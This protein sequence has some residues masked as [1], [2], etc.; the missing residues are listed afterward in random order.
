MDH[1]FY[2]VE[3]SQEILSNTFME[4]TFASFP[5]PLTSSVCN[6]LSKVVRSMQSIMFLKNSEGSYL[7]FLIVQTTLWACSEH[8]PWNHS[9]WKFLPTYLYPSSSLCGQW[10]G[11]HQGGVLAARVSPATEGGLAGLRVESMPGMR[12]KS[13]IRATCWCGSHSLRRRKEAQKAETAGEDHSCKEQQGSNSS[14]PAISLCGFSKS[15]L[16]SWYL[17]R[18]SF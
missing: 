4:F 11:P 6:F 5:V 14:S 13:L 18:W 3:N 9:W 2:L 17:A 12:R 16:F 7:P 8:P 15:A 10:R 1:L